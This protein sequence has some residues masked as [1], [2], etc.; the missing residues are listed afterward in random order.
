MAS[1]ILNWLSG[2]T[3]RKLP[4][5]SRL[6]S[7]PLSEVAPDLVDKEFSASY[8]ASRDTIQHTL[9]HPPRRPSEDSPLFTT[10][11]AANKRG[12]VTMTLPDDG[13][14]CVPVFSAPVRAAD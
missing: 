5:Y 9:L 6:R 12:I 11:I 10:L 14:R 7:I 8:S 13:G 2:R 3:K 1:A 4:G